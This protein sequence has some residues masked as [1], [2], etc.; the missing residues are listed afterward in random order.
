MKFSAV[1]KGTREEVPVEIPGATSDGKPVVAFV[2]PLTE[3]EEEAVLASAL[4]DAKAAGVED[5]K[6]GV[7]LYDAAVMVHTV[8]AGLVDPDSPKEDRAAFFDGGAEQ[9]RKNFG[10][11]EIGYMFERHEA[12][13]DA[14]SPSIR[15]VTPEQLFEL[16]AAIARSDS[17]GPF[18]G[19][20]PALRCR[21]ARTTARQLMDSLAG[22]SPPGLPSLGTH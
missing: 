1:Q 3:F 18:V 9:L 20:R 6:R 10:S 22:K 21:W 5:P 4:A 13:Q 19:L 2:R 8:V 16:T 7:E 17:D 12:H 15:K 14:C 11:D